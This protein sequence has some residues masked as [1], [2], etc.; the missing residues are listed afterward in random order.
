MKKLALII[1]LNIHFFA[2]SQISNEMSKA[3][4]VSLDSAIYLDRKIASMDFGWEKAYLNYF[5]K[6]ISCTDKSIVYSF[7]RECNQANIFSVTEL[8]YSY[9]KFG[10][11][12]I[13]YNSQ[14][15]PF[16]DKLPKFT[17]YIADSLK[18]TKKYALLVDFSRSPVHGN[19]DA[20]VIKLKKRGKFKFEQTIRYYYQYRFT[21]P[22]QRPIKIVT[23]PYFRFDSTFSIFDQ[24]QKFNKYFHKGKVTPEYYEDKFVFKLKPL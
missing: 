23:T 1:L 6:I 9:N 10:D 7:T 5:V 17:K 15:I 22:H 2:F 18:Q 11:V 24:V 13:F 3:F 20:F 19:Y 21:P 14:K 4:Q 12:L 16:C 8:K